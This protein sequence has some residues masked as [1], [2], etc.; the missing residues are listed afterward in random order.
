[1]LNIGVGISITAVDISYL[2]GRSSMTLQLR[3]DIY[4][5]SAACSGI[6]CKVTFRVF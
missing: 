4:D 3:G 2:A 6:L 1:M 5:N